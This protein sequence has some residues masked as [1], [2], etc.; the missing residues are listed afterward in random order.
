LTRARKLAWRRLFERPFSRYAFAV[1]FVAFTFVL[2]KALEP[3]TGTGAPFVLLFGAVLIISL[4]AGPG[5]AVFATLVSAPLAAEQFVVRAGYQPLQAAVQAVLFTVEGGVV[6]YLSFLITRARRAAEAAGE[7]LRLA[8]EAAAIVS[9]DL[10][11]VGKQLRW[12]RDAFALLGVSGEVA[13]IDAWMGLI[14]PD[15]RAVFAEAHQRSLDPTGRGEMRSES[16]IVRADGAVRWF[17][18]MGRTTF[19]DT[20]RGRIA[21]RQVGA[22]VD[23][24]DRR[25][26]EDERQ[27]FVSLLENSSDFI[28]IA[29][30][31]GKPI[32]INPAGRRMVGLAADHP[33]EKTEILEYYPPE[34]R[35]FAADVIVK[36]MV[37]EGRWAGETYFRNWQTGEVI[38]VSDEHFMIRDASGTRVLGMGTVTRDISHA[39]RITDRL[40]ESEERVRLTIDEAPIGMALVAVDGRFVRVNRRLCEIVGY[41]ADELVQR[42]FHDITHPDDLDADVVLAGRLAR[43]EIPR[44]QLE[45][46]YVR[47]DGRIVTIML[48]ASMLRAHDGALY[49][50]AQIED[51]TER[52]RAEQA[53]RFSEARFSG[54]ISISADAIISIDDD[55]RITLFNRGAELIFGY[56]RDEVIGAPLDLLMP[57]R[58]R[59]AHRGHVGQFAA[60][61]ETAR[62]MGERVAAIVGRRKNGEEFPADAAISK[63]DVEGRTILTVAMRDVTEVE[64]VEKQ[65]RFL[66]EAGSVLS[67]SLDY[68]QTLATVGELAVRELADWCI[69]EIVEREE[70]ARRLKVVSADP[71]R[72][73]LCA[74]LEQVHLDRTRSHLGHT[75]VE[76]K[77]PLLIE[78]IKSEQIESFAQ[79]DEHLAMLRAMEPRSLIELPLLIRGEILGVLV[80]ISSTPD[81]LYGPADLP[82]AE[83]IAERAALAIENGR[84][85]QQAV[86][87]TELRDEVLG[88]VAHDLRNPLSSILLQSQLLRPP[89]AGPDRRSHRPAEVIQRAAKRMNRLIRDLLDV[90]TM[91]AGRFAIEHARISPSELLAEFVEAQRPMAAAST[92][93]LR[94]DV[95]DEL[96]DIWGDSSRV[97]QVLE[98]LIGNAS[99]F[100]A[101]GG[102]I[103]IGAVPRSGEVVFWVA[104]SGCGIS[105]EGLPHVFD[106]FWQARKGDRKG[107]GLGLPITRGIVEAH[108]GRIW[109]E[110]TPGRGTIF[111][112]TI[113]EA[114]RTAASHVEP[115]T[116]G[117]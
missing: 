113:P 57:E 45:K 103:T 55:Q 30:P 34:E 41:T 106:R 38:P 32:W 8:N 116:T 87:A 58:M 40:R 21:I 26:R 39:R 31:T 98:N 107:A 15:D 11:V 69:V 1:I 88:I 82:F 16:R 67:S 115:P 85:Y 52:K 114:A 17:F 77:R 7:R 3:A 51:I 27:V 102:L 47:K 48:S 79:G 104:D 12:S 75:A 59:E 60:G 10:D 111:F 93:E 78:R 100:T 95:S 53:L 33:V 22:A 29:D 36:S 68:E 117:R 35:A 80:F 73:A 19:E 18:W 110:S 49:Y 65:Q 28:G 71:G 90:S 20:A 50:I 2:R 6:V 9:W 46:R 4:L 13:A 43:G 89:D 72:A 99:K 70:R 83:A 74:Q 84:L 61:P 94:L 66:A 92:L 25:Q 44:Y 37:E 108:G 97:L 109:V 64:R 24:T 105:A 63:L 91:E 76:T 54:I 14:H 42:T 112:F 23:I 96:P 56:T 62:R 86:H 101:P 81:R 5:P